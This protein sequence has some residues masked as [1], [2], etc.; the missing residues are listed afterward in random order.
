MIAWLYSAQL[1]LATAVGLMTIVMGL[2]QRKPSGI[3][4]GAI[5][6]V[7]VGLLVQLVASIV[8][9]I[10]GERAKQ[11]TVEF[12][13]YLIVALIIPVAAAFWALIERSRWSTVVLGVGA[14][15]VAVMLV[16]MSQIWTGSY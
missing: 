3:S 15:T 11:D 14:L 8:L 4:I 10:S 1:F 9:V 13:A 16:R 12:F 6:L 7:Q 5:A 2:A